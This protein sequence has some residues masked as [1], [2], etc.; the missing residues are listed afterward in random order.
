[1]SF[2]KSRIVNI[3]ANMVQNEVNNIHGSIHQND[4]LQKW[5]DG[6]VID[7]KKFRGWLNYSVHQEADFKFIMRDV[8]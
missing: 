4:L 2:K 6:W 8:K 7:H 3:P 5:F 1:M